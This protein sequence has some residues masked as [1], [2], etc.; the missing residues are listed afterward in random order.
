[1]AKILAVVC[2][3]CEICPF[4]GLWELFEADIPLVP[5]V[6]IIAGITLLISIIRRKSPTKK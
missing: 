5:N 1:M 2:H 6:L 3:K 4:A